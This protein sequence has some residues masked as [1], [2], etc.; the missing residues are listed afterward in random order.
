MSSSGEPANFEKL[1]RR[2]ATDPAAVRELV[3]A[4][5]PRMRSFLRRKGL[6]WT[7]VE[8]VAQDAWMRIFRYL[9]TYDSTRPFLNWAFTITRHAWL[10]T[11]RQAGKQPPL[12]PLLDDP[13]GGSELQMVE[14]LER[15]SHILRGLSEEY[16]TIFLLRFQEGCSNRQISERLGLTEAVVRAKCCRA[17]GSF[18]DQ[19]QSGSSDSIG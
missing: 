7:D 13:L 16:R 4:V 8:D 17:V 11:L 1:A 6:S 5:T 10:D 2:A 14:W 15:S 9:K 3:E 18:L 12:L 19:L